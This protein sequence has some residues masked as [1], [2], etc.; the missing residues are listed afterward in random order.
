[1]QLII[2]AHGFD[3]TTRLKRQA[4]EKIDL[5]LDRIADDVEVVRIFLAD[6]NGPDVGGVDKACRIVVTFR[7]HAPIEVSDIDENVHE[8]VER[9]TDRLGVIACEC[10][11]R[12][13]ATTNQK[14][15]RIIYR[16]NEPGF[17]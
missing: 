10:A 2:H 11:N 7:Q 14:P 6:T 9:A 15:S 5:A 16:Q 3:L 1:M 12:R 4:S 13:D 17:I 8:V